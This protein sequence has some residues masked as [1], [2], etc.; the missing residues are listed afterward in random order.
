MIAMAGTA[1]LGGNLEV[2]D[3][4]KPPT[5]KHCNVEAETITVCVYEMKDWLWLV[6]E[7]TFV[8]PICKVTEES[9]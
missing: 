6:G 2:P 8:C 4:H 3:D 5:C 1:H 9:Q 7:G